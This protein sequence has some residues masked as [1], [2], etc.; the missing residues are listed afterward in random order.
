MTI[1]PSYLWAVFNRGHKAQIKI[2]AKYWMSLK[3]IAP[4][5]SRSLTSFVCFPERKGDFDLKEKGGDG[6]RGRSHRWDR[7]NQLNMSE[8]G[9]SIQMSLN[10]EDLWIWQGF[11]IHSTQRMKYQ[12]TL[13]P[14]ASTGGFFIFLI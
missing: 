9:A 8:R 2:Q 6:K 5:S 7:K 13:Y 4:W 10:N 3:L 12:T 1:I 11:E 14:K